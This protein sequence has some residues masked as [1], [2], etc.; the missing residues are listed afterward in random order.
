MPFFLSGTNLLLGYLRANVSDGG[1][2]EVSEPSQ[3]MNSPRPTNNVQARGYERER[4]NT[5][6]VA[7]GDETAGQE[8]VVLVG[9]AVQGFHRVTVLHIN[10]TTA[11]TTREG[12]SHDVA[13]AAEAGMWWK[14]MG[15][16]MSDLLVTLLP[17]SCWSFRDLT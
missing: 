15:T 14:C 13:A 9:G 11:H 12:L 7:L 2:L 5:V 10:R 4:L 17:R 1:G 16:S 8:E 6:E 3:Y